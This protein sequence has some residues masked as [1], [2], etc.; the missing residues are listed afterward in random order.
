VEMICGDITDNKIFNN[1]VDAYHRNDCDFL[2][3]TPPCQ[4]MSIA[5]KM[6]ESDPRNELIKYVI[7]FVEKTKPSNI[8]IENV[9]GLLKFY[10]MINGKRILIKDYIIKSF[11][12]MGYFVNYKIVDAANFGTPQHRRRAIFLIS[13]IKKWEFPAQQNLISVRDAIGDLPSIEAGEASKIKYHYAKEHNEN[14]ILW[15]KNTPSG[16]T[17]HF[18]KKNYPV[19]KNGVKIKG[20]STTYKRI[21][22]DGPA[23]TIT[24]ANGSISSQNNVHPGRLKKDGTYSDARVLT[25][26]ELLRLSGL[27]DNWD[28]PEWA[29]DN[30]VREV[31]GESFPPKFCISM[32]ESMPR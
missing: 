9:P 32:I 4:G 13:K 30:L 17:A 27:P 25:I 23:P 21:S 11:E 28:I 19:K 24:M 26:L 31:I 12:K 18:N 22:W 8:L 10:I 29:S 6:N 5:G 2:I 15:M 16:K 14:H 1:I 3:A 20:F 7:K